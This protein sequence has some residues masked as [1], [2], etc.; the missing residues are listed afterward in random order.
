[1]YAVYVYVRIRIP[2]GKSIFTAGDF[3][4]LFGNK[5]NHMKTINIGILAHVDAG[6][7]TTE[8]LLYA[9]GAISE[10]GASK[11]RGRTWI[12]RSGSDYHSSHFLPVAQ[13]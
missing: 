8:S 9:S 10:L 3:Y 2:S 4:A 11:K 7:T 1:M 13:M 12:L 6:K 5:G